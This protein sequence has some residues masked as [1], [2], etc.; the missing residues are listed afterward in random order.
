MANTTTYY[1]HTAQLILNQSVDINNLKAM[2]L[3]NNKAA[4]FNATH[5]TVNQVAGSLTGSPLE[6]ANEVYGYGWDQG[7]EL[8]AGVTVTTVNTNDALLDATDISVTPSG[9]DIGP[10]Y[11]ALIYDATNSKPLAFNDFGEVK[12]AGVGTLFLLN[13]PNGVIPMTYTPA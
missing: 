8:L 12:L 11:A 10:T 9:G 1:N 13:F 7:G 2:L 6:R 4:L 3:D 5:T